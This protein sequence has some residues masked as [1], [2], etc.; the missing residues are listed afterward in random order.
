VTML[1]LLFP[2]AILLMVGI[3]LL[4]LLLIGIDIDSVLTIVDVVVDGIL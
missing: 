2:M 4:T 1:L 3:L